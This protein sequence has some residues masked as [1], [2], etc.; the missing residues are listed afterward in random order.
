MTVAKRTQEVK[1]TTPENLRQLTLKEMEEV[2]VRYNN[3][4]VSHREDNYMNWDRE[5][6]LILDIPSML[7]DRVENNECDGEEA[8]LDNET[9][10]NRKRENDKADHTFLL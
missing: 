4:I 5:E 6:R 10:R 9:E 3:A 1:E 2:I 7:E 8:I